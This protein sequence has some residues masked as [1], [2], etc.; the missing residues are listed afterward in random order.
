MIT[1]RLCPFLCLSLLRSPR[2]S[3][4][5]E[6]SRPYSSARSIP[7]H[8]SHWPPVTP[9]PPFPFPI[10]V[11]PSSSF[12]SLQMRPCVCV[13]PPLLVLSVP[14]PASSRSRAVPTIV[15]GPMSHPAA[16]SLHRVPE[17]VA[18][19]RIARPYSVSGGPMS[20]LT[21]SPLPW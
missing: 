14:A 19:Q 7:P 11:S 18:S 12:S 5:V 10:L 4:V 8:W 1:S 17:L 6:M 13:P 3:P 15:G 21:L 20:S 9:P 2:V 16:P